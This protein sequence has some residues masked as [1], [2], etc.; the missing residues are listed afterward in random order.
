MPSGVKAILMPSGV[1]NCA[2]PAVR[3]IER[4]QRYAGNRGRQREGQVDHGVDN[5]LARKPVA[6]QHPGED[7]A[8]DDIDDRRRQRR[9]RS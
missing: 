2:D 6:H 4:R 1:R 8:E 3:R 5:A 7:D 9:C